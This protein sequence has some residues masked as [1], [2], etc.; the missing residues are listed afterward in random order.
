[1]ILQD[2]KEFYKIFDLMCNNIIILLQKYKPSIK[3]QDN[4]EVHIHYAYNMH[5]SYDFFIR[6]GRYKKE[7]NYINYNGYIY[8]FTFSS[9]KRKYLQ[10]NDITRVLSEHIDSELSEVY[11]KEMT[12]YLWNI[13][14]VINESLHSDMVRMNEM[15]NQ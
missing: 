9:M 13:R 8:P 11:Q 6:I 14:R 2:F 10:H 3:F 15:L 5:S 12:E 7:D 1:M 4:G